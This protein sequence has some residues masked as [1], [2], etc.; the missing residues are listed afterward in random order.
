[1]KRQHLLLIPTLLAFTFVT[2][3]QDHAAHAVHTAKTPEKLSEADFDRLDSDKDGLLSRAEIPA[4]HPLL[5]HFSMA[6]KSRD[7]KLDKREFKLAL[8]MI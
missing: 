2:N 7:G 6:D 4:N 8:S 3:A 1:M 5:E